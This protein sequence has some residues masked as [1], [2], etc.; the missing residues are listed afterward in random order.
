MAVM[1]AVTDKG[2][3]KVTE[4]I[5]ILMQDPLL[6]SSVA[7]SYAKLI[8]RVL[9]LILRHYLHCLDNSWVDH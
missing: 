2:K 8:V 5:L 6:S 4:K 1:M 7:L 9:L 3:V